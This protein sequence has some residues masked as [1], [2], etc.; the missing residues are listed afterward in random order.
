M[1]GFFIMSS[2][3]LIGTFAFFISFCCIFGACVLIR[4]KR[5]TDDSDDDLGYLE[6]I[7]N[8]GGGEDDV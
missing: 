3:Q 4:R 8:D 1:T 5:V 7:V 6:N 2:V